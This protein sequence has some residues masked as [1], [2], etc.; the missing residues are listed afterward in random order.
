MD[1]NGVNNHK[2]TSLFN[3]QRKLY[4]N[5]AN[6]DNKGEDDFDVINSRLKKRERSN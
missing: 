4:K 3:V 2:Y 1:I 6:D 5:N